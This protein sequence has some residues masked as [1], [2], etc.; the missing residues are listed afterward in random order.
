MENSNTHTR[1]QFFAD[2]IEA[3]VRN[4]AEA[5]GSGGARLGS[6]EPQQFLRPPGALAEEEFLAKCTR[7]TDCL[8]AC[9]HNAIRRLGEEMRG[10][11]ATPV[12]VPEESPCKLCPDLPCAAAC[13]T[14]A[15]RLVDL[16]EVKM[17]K[18][19]INYQACYQAAGQPCDYCITACPLKAD[20]ISADERGVPKVK[21][22]GC[23][24]CGICAY[25]CPADA[26]KVTPN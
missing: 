23:V 13:Q 10:A 21:D 4:V 5:Y 3:A 16:C 19:R 22:G 6:H 24:G 1:R 11:G 26:I 15:L 25:Y 14:G 12:I 18:A 20:A 2:L 8:L 17:G 9:P 7:C